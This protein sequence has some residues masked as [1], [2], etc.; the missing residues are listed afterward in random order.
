M[1]KERKGRERGRYVG[2]KEQNKIKIES[3]K[4][5]KQDEGSKEGRKQ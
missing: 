1:R 2:R 3:R 5:D 4:K